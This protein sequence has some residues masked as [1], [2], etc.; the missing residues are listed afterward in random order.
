[1]DFKNI[2]DTISNQMPTYRGGLTNHLPMALYSLQYLGMNE[3]KMYDYIA[4]YEKEKGI[5]K[6]N[7][8]K[9]V[10]SNLKDHLGHT[11]NY[12]ELSEYFKAEIKRW[13]IEKTVKKYIDILIEGSSGDAF[14]GL[15]RLAYAVEIESSDE[16]ARSLAYLS[17]CYTNFCIDPDILVEKDPLETM[18][19]LEKSK[20]FN[21]K[22]FKKSLIIGRMKEVS[23]DENVMKLLN[24]LPERVINETELSK[25]T[26]EL[27]AMTED[28]TMLH[29]FTSTHA[30]IVLLP[31]ILD[32]KRA[33]NLHWLH[34][35]IAYLSTNC[36]KINNISIDTLNT[37]WSLIFEKALE[38]MDEHTYKLIYSLHKNYLKYKYKEFS[39]LYGIMAA[40]RVANI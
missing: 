4:W 32:K 19:T 8:P 25:L 2:L 15:I 13:G 26:L 20:Y 34:L 27:Y 39:V 31:F 37:D 40:K 1:M 17:D 33:L 18:K 9:F 30:L 6:I 28:F 12:V 35:Q 16:I 24:K 36:T 22:T 11:K 14:H 7:E 10:I 3:E 29:A 21:N 5:S 38:S 23:E